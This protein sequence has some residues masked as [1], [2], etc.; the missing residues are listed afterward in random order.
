MP[1]YAL[2]LISGAGVESDGCVDGG[3]VQWIAIEARD[4]TRRHRRF[5]QTLVELW[6]PFIQGGQDGEC[7]NPG[8]D[9]RAFDAIEAHDLGR[10]VVESVVRVGEEKFAGVVVWEVDGSIGVGAP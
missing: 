6:C 7:G 8:V 9:G 10:I 3:L 4:T 2:D 5:A 1:A